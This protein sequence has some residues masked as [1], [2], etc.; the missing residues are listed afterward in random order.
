MS[1]N[2]GLSARTEEV[3]SAQRSR[4]HRQDGEIASLQLEVEDLE[5]QV[6]RIGRGLWDVLATTAVAADA[7]PGEITNLSRLQTALGMYELWCRVVDGDQ[8]G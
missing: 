5:S 8:H 7:N 4:L 1:S 3:I 2:Y 6:E